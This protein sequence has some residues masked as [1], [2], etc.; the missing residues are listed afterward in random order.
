LNKIR[1]RLLATGETE[2]IAGSESLLGGSV[3]WA[4][5]S[6]CPDSTRF[7]VN[8][9]SPQSYAPFPTRFQLFIP[10]R[11]DS[12]EAATKSSVW[13]VSVLG[14]TA[15]KLR[16]DADAFSVS[17]DGAL[18]AFGTNAAQLG[19]REIWLMNSKGLQ[20]RKLYEAPANTAVGGLNWLCDGL[21]VVYFQLTGSGGELV[22]RDLQG[23]PAI[24]LVQYSGWWSVTDF[25]LLADGRMIY[26]REGNLWELPIHVS[27]G[28]SVAMPRKLTNWSGFWLGE[29]ST[30]GDGK[31]LA[32]Q[33]WAWQ[34]T[35]SVADIEAH[36]THVSPPRHLTLSE[37][38]NAAETWTPD[39]AALIFRSRRD[40]R[41]HLF[42]QA[43]DSDTEQPL[44]MGAEE[45]GGAAISPDGSWLFYLDCGPRMTPGCDQITPLMRI[46]IHG[47]EPHEVLRSNTYGRP[48]CTIAP[49]NLCV[50]A[51]KSDDGK[52]I[53]FTSF[54]AFGGRGAE[55]ARFE[56]ET[57]APDYNWAISPDASAIAILKQGDNRIHILSLRGQPPTIVTVPRWNNLASLYWSADGKGWFTIDKDKVG[58]TLLYVDLQG[59]GHVVLQLDGYSVAYAIPSPDGRHLAI[60]ATSR[61][62]NVWLMENL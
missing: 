28:K 7:I 12:A 15:Q 39:S 44:V 14:K 31:Q 21:H 36:G 10:S 1:I 60:V 19:D 56:T 3:E 37:H 41:T 62:N 43:L 49:A 51:E 33:R 42:K 32:F 20:A 55:I 34:T 11:G 18:I 5:A 4:I 6:W 46:P 35:V 9:R 61:N 59:E 27:S 52:P 26:A 16:D 53:V 25:V 45:V 48:R 47:G 29:M 40:G 57:G 50:I 30:A 58:V 24:P 22:S 8:A 2:T 13:I 17:P 23:G 54:D 38:M